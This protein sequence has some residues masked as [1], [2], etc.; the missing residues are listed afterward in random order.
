MKL[1]FSKPVLVP[2]VIWLLSGLGV[3]L[4]LYSLQRGELTLLTLP[5]SLMSFQVLPLTM[6]LFLMAAGHYLLWF[7]ARKPWLLKAGWWWQLVASGA[8]T[9]QIVLRIWESHQVLEQGH[10][11]M[12]NLYEVSLLLLALIG[13]VG[14]WLSR[15][16]DQEDNPLGAF[17]APIVVVAVWFTLWLASIGQADPKHLVPSLQSFWLPFH[18]LA[19]FIAYAAFMVAAAAGLMHLWRWR[20]DKRGV[21]SSLPSQEV[22]DR[23][24]F[25]AVAVGFPTFTLAVLLGAIWAYE[26]WGGYWSWDPKETWALIVWLV[27]AVY[28]H[29]RMSRRGPYVGFAVWL[30]VGFLVTLFCYIGVN[31]FLSGLHSYGSLQ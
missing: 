8:L 29:L 27:Y 15:G 28:L 26:A 2:S 4:P 3:F 7:V 21:K 5:E 19:N 9:G 20:Q 23:I 10:W 22:C 12:S 31:M 30:V 16:G 24:G 25:R 11:G 6:G 13:L 18:V 14:C 1:F 17:L